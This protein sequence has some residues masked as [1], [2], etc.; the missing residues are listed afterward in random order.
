MAKNSRQKRKK[1]LYFVKLPTKEDFCKGST[2]YKRNNQCKGQ[3]WCSF[4][5]LPKDIK[6]IPHTG[7]KASLDRC[8]Y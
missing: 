4:K 2:V 1:Y 6:R 3:F 7:D 5:I 8:G